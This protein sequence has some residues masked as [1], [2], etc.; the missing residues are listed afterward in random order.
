MNNK[1]VLIIIASVFSLLCCQKN[2]ENNPIN[3][4]DNSINSN[5]SSKNLKVKIP[6]KKA[7]SLLGDNFIPVASLN[8]NLDNDSNEEILLAYKLN[9]TSPISLVIFDLLDND[10]L[11]MKFQ[12]KTEMYNSDFFSIES[13][14][15]SGKD[16]ICIIA[17]GKN[18]ENLTK[19][20]IFTYIDDAFKMIADFTAYY[21]ILIN[22]EDAVENEGSVKYVKIKNIDMIDIDQSAANANI[23]KKNTYQWDT[24]SVSFKLVKSESIYSSTI[25]SIDQSILYSEDKYYSYIKGFWY[26]QD[27]KALL[28]S[29]K[30]NPDDF[31][32]DKIRLIY[33]SDDPR[34]I[35]VK[36]GDYVSTYSVVKIVKSWNQKP[37]IRIIL[38]EDT[39]QPNIT[40]KFIDLTLMDKNL[41][42]VIGPENYDN[43][44]YIKL[45][46]PFE[47]YINEKKEEINKKN[48]NSAAE[49]FTGSFKT[50]DNINIMFEKN[51]AFTVMSN[52]KSEKG[53][54]KLT[55]EK[56]GL[57]VTLMFEKQNTILKNYNFLLKII[58]DKSGFSLIPIK[59]DYNGIIIDD[60]NPLNFYNFKL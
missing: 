37:G 43:D 7:E 59:F 33:I 12:Y 57:I 51:Q 42:S 50:K 3:F 45:P 41:L 44:N 18:N 31:T 32:N 28:D 9:N 22:F 53:Y 49:F 24:A 10:I 38:K 11:K 39:D 1:I 47:E 2:S 46:K 25:A 5:L 30:I 6:Y 26:P 48:I 54:Y 16:D 58:Q 20:Y 36:Y 40:S 13:R 21:S 14:H 56:Q 8:E 19:M 34:Q 23:Q 52:N 17:D 29:N 15:L 27:Y 55:S 35:C 60:L 4:S